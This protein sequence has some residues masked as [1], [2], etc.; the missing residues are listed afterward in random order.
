MKRKQII[1][2]LWAIISLLVALSFIA[3]PFFY[4]GF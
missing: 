2:I 1:K 4:G 3:L